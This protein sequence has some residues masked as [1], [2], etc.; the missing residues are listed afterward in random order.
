MTFYL[1]ASF[2]DS[3]A[4]EKWNIPLFVGIS[5]ISVTAITSPSSRASTFAAGRNLRIGE[6]FMWK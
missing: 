3:L 1:L 6:P 4:R 2:F 5:V